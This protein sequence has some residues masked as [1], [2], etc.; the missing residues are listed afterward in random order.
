MNSAASAP[1]VSE[2][3]ERYAVDLRRT[4]DR[5][6]AIGAA[7]LAASFAPEP[8]RAEAAFALIEVMAER[9]AHVD[10]SEPRTVPRLA[11]MALGDQ[12][13]VIG[14]ELLIAARAQANPDILVQTADELLDL[15]RRV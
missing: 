1:L 11:D 2:A 5:L 10:G 14:R 7:R 8:T 15:R 13:A 12:M 4:V 3:A 6:R 9:V